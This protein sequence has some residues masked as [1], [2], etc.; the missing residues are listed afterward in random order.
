MKTR[1]ELKQ[2]LETKL[3]KMNELKGKGRSRNCWHREYSQGED[4]KIS[5]EIERLEEEISKLRSLVGK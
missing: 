4:V 5:L 2:E 1:E 3:Q